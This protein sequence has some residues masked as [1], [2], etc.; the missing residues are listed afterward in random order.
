MGQFSLNFV[1]STGLH[2][3]P[4]PPTPFIVAPLCSPAFTPLST[5]SPATG[6]SA[7]HSGKLMQSKYLNFGNDFKAL[8]AELLLNPPCS[9]FS[10][11]DLCRAGHVEQSPD[12]IPG[13]HHCYFPKLCI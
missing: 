7:G 1:S 8:N 12:L 2:S 10:D 11:M 3:A 6:A 5:T 9:L 13:P 4:V